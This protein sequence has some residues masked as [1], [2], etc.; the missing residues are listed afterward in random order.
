MSEDEIYKR[1]ME[2]CCALKVQTDEITE[3][4]LI[5]ELGA[6]CSC[7]SQRHSSIV[8]TNP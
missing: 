8:R 4:K 3:Q 7:I 2:I 6:L 1:I 5:Q